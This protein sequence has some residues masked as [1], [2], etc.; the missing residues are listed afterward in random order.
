R[1]MAVLFASAGHALLEPVHVSCVSHVPAEPR[2]TT[3]AAANPSAGQLTPTPS[4][5]SAT[6]QIP[7]DAR[8][9]DVLF[10]SMGHAADPPVH[11]SCG[12]HVPPDERH[13]NVAGWNAFAGQSLLT[14][15]Q[16]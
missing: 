9:C 13:T 6:S 16:F 15:S 2:H 11:V 8:H 10:A 12:S 7:T 1:H 5:L 3:V 14:P 4:Q